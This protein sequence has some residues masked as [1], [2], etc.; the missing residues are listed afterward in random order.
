MAYRAHVIISGEP[1][2]AQ[3][4][5]TA[6]LDEIDALGLTQEI[7]V[8]EATDLTVVPLGVEAVIYP[9]AVH[10]A[11]LTPEDARLIAEEHLLK[12]RPVDKFS[13]HERAVEPLP[14]P[15]P[16]KSAWCCAMSA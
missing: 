8:H 11:D 1:E 12:G 3:E 16:K 15:S 13:F 5:R 9:D 4:V 6:L 14:E 7:E 2:Q 10:Y